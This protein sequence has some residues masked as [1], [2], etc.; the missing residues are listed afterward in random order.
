MTFPFYKPET[1][2]RP[3]RP[4]ELPVSLRAGQESPAGYLPDPALAA[5]TNVA[6]LLG[7]PLLVTGE[8]GSGKTQLAYHLAWQLGYPTPLVFNAKS[9]S[10]ARELLY[11]Y[12]ALGRFQGSHSSKPLAVA[13][14]TGRDVLRDALPYLTFQALGLAILQANPAD[15]V[16][17]FLPDGFEHIG[18]ARSVVLI[19]EIDKAPRDFPN[20]LLNEIDQMSFRV[21]ELA[22]AGFSAPETMRPILVVTSNS[23]KNLPDAFLRR[24]AYYHIPFPDRDRLIQIVESRTGITVRNSGERLHEALQLFELLR[25]PKAALKKK[26][27]TAELLGFLLYLSKVIPGGGSFR[28]HET[29]S[30]AALSILVKLESDRP[31]ARQ[32]LETWRDSAP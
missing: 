11:T 21:P 23:E 10:T 9:T 18:P 4:A 12:D 24:C 14:D 29:E 16:R 1:G 25:G 22:N 13:E 2:V 15:S 17:K 6:L 19:D 26:P 28:K 5:A 31:A 27:S 20:D 30:I 7:Q 32:V 3:D 8:P